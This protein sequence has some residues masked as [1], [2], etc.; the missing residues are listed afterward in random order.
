MKRILSLMLLTIVASVTAITYAGTP[1]RQ[2]ELP[3][4][5]RTFLTKHFP[6]DDIRKA[7]KEQGRRGMEYEVDLKSGAEIDFRENGDW[8]E[9]KAA[10]GNSV[11]AA[12]IPTAISKYITS[13][14][15]GQKIVEISRKRGGYEI[16]LSNGTELKLTETAKPMPSRQGFRRGNHR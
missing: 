5:V 4:T 15:R 2:S 14:Y 1:V 6:G 3:K 8:K 13:S 10:R 16:E 12:L 7:E 9:I 11:P